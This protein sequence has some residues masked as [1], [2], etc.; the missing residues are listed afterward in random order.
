[1]RLHGVDALAG[2][3]LELEGLQQRREVVGSDFVL[4]F[5]VVVA[6][7][8]RGWRNCARRTRVTY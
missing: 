2:L 5:Q 4:H 6:R 7:A 8:L 3:A 1:M